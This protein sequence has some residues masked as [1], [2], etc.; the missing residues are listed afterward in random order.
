MDY[1]IKGA[2]MKVDT[3]FKEAFWFHLGDPTS[4]LNTQKKG[5]GVP[6]LQNVSL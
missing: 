3:M 1:G 6:V 4:L 2:P 5:R